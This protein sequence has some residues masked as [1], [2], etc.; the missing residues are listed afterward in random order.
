MRSDKRGPTVFCIIHYYKC[1]IKGIF[2][3]SGWS[4]SLLIYLNHTLIHCYSC[5]VN[6]TF[7][8]T[9]LFKNVKLWTFC[10]MIQQYSLSCLLVQWTLIITRFSGPEKYACDDKTFLYQGYKN[11]EIQEKIKIWDHKNNLVIM[12]LCFLYQCSL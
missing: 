7:I 11:N 8:N 5:Q 12:K 9:S 1:V 3:F 4:L 10:C 2:I 6:E